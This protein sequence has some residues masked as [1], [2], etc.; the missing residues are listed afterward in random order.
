[1]WNSGTANTSI[2]AT[3]NTGAI[4]SGFDNTGQFVSG[5]GNSADQ[6]SGLFNKASGGALLNGDISGF[7]NTGIPN[8]TPIAAGSDSGLFNTGSFVSGLFNVQ[9]LLK[10]L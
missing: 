10:Q 9:Q 3:G 1:L 4:T 2:G 7:F 5:F 8:V 6:T